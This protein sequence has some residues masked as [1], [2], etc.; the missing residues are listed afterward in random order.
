MNNNLKNDEEMKRSF[1]KDILNK[2]DY[3]KVLKKL[4]DYR[5]LL[6]RKLDNETREN[7]IYSVYKETLGANELDKEFKTYFWQRNKEQII[8]KINEMEVI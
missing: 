8:N 3:E 5:N 1:D 6:N 7:V 2:F 4:E